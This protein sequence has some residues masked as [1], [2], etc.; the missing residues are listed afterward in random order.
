MFLTLAPKLRRSLPDLVIFP[1]R[2]HLSRT[3][4]QLPRH[5]HHGVRGEGRGA[6]LRKHG[7]EG[8]RK[9]VPKFKRHCHLDM[10]T[11]AGLV[12]L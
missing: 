4:K 3:Q 8:K 11:E 10:K 5:L 6:K 9:A 1:P 2:P 12:G 7:G